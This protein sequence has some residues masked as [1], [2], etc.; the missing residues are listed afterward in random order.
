MAM[1]QSPE[2][3]ILVELGHLR[4]FTDIAG[5]HVIRMDNIDPQ[6]RQELAQAA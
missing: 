1:G 4:P 6:R 3:T 5:L 2:R